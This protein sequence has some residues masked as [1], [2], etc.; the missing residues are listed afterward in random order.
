MIILYPYVPRMIFISYNYIK[1]LSPNIENL[2]SSDLRTILITTDKIRLKK[3]CT[4]NNILNPDTYDSDVKNTL[5]IT[6]DRFGCGC[7]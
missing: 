3:I 4:E 6:K 2:Y 5:F 1:K 7:F